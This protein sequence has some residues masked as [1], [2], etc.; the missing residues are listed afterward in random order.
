MK[1]S[2]VFAVLVNLPGS[3]TRGHVLLQLCY[4]GVISERL[5]F[6]SVFVCKQLESVQCPKAVVFRDALERRGVSPYLRRS[7]EF[8]VAHL[9]ATAS[10]KNLLRFLFPPTSHGADGRSNVHPPSRSVSDLCAAWGCQLNLLLTFL[11]DLALRPWEEEEEV[12]CLQGE[13][14]VAAASGVEL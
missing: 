11:G 7:T 6:Q 2:L 9:R 1:A 12:K 8:F 10:K 4:W 14:P 5:L 13:I 3:G